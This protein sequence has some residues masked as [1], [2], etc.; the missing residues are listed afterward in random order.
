MDTCRLI[1]LAS[2]ILRLSVCQYPCARSPLERRL[3][4]QGSLELKTIHAPNSTTQG[5]SRDRRVERAL[6]GI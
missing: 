6:A 2:R 5:P 3:H 4:D 1:L